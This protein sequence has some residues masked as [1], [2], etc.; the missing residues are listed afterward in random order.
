MDQAQTIRENRVNPRPEIAGR[1][2]GSTFVDRAR[3]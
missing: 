3:D 2:L 1:A